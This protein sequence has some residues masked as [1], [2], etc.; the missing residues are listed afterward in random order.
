M[1]KTASKLTL[2]HILFLFV[3]LV[4]TYINFP[5]F[6]NPV[7]ISIHL[8]DFMVLSTKHYAE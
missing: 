7:I 8:L 5:N 4:N 1:F 3:G 2:R 6:I